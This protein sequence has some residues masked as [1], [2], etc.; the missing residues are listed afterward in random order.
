M[1]IRSVNHPRVKKWK[2]LYSCED[3]ASEYF[4]SDY[5]RVISLGL[6]LGLVKELAILE[7]LQKYELF[8]K[9]DRFWIS[10][11]VVHEVGI[12][13]CW[14]AV[15]KKPEL[16]I[17][18]YERILLLDHFRDGAELGS[19]IRSARCFGFD[20]VLLTGGSLNPWDARVSR[21]AQTNVL[22]F[23]VL[24]L[25]FPDAIRL[26]RDHGVSI[27]T[28]GKRRAVPVEE[29]P[30][31]ERM[32][33]LLPGSGGSSA[34]LIAA[35]DT[36]CDPVLECMDPAALAHTAAIMMYACRNLRGE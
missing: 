17:K 34:D 20:G 4:I 1:T 29:L 24:N 28:I 15:L 5:Y 6:E 30:V 23:P 3:G 12:K 18:K 14:F 16:S 31:S 7:K 32:A 11:E 36:V 21:T 13:S 2:A 25:P 26:L 22:E 33:V 19:M 8:G 27:V 35:S 10:D 9:N